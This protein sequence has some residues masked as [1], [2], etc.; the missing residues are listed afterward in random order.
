[1]SLATILDRLEQHY[2]KQKRPG[3]AGAYEM[4]LYANCGYPA[5]DISC[6]KGFEA[7]RRL[8]GLAP[9]QILAAPDKQLAGIARL[10][11]I[12]PELRATRLKEIAGRVRDKFSGDLDAALEGPAAQAKKILRQF[13]TIGEPGAEKILLFTNRATIAA[14]PSGQVHVL[15]RL[16]FGQEKKSYAAGYRA[17]Q[18]AVLTEIPAAIAQLQRAYLLIQCHGR[19][20][21]KRS[22]PVCQRCPV[23]K[24][25]PYYNSGL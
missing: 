20:L 17:A 6:P 12:V 15:H 5:N 2:G 11:G 14:I 16:G 3:P 4:V 23:S 22:R 1:M 24:D 8:V 18:E 13:P 10:G 21:C 7:L 25:C 19:E 9:G